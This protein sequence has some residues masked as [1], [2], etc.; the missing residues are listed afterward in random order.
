MRIDIRLPMGAMF[1]LLG[2]ILAVWGLVPNGKMYDQSLGIDINLWWGLVL[3]AF[4]LVCLGLAGW[5]IK[6]RGSLDELSEHPTH[7][8]TREGEQ[9]T[10]RDGQAGERKSGE[11]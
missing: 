10:N 11:G 9:T 6:R 5:A 8:I 2:L 3:L 7:V 4:G 1:T